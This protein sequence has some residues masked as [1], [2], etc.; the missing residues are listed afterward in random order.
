MRRPWALPL[1]PLYWCGL[2]V[3]NALYRWGW[4]RAKRLAWPVVSVGSLSAGGAG[5]TPVVMMLAE[6]LG[7]HGVQVDVL[8]RGYGRG[9]GVVEEVDAEGSARRFGDEPLEM[10]RRGLRVVMGADRWAAG[11]FAE[12]E[13]E[14]K[15]NTVATEEKTQRSLRVAV[16]VLDDG[17][18]HRRLARDLDLALLT[19]EDVG[20]WLLPAGNLREPMAA[21]ARAHVVVVRDEEASELAGVI[22]AN[23]E[24][25]VWMVRRELVLPVERPQRSVVFC[26]IARPKS[27][28]A[29]L[30]QAGCATAGEIVFPDHHAYTS[31]HFDLLIDAAAHAG[32]DGFLTTA[33][34]AVKI[35]PEERMKLEKIG[36]VIVAALRVTLVDEDAAMKTLRRSLRLA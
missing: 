23:T 21:L 28:L 6:L 15:I 22:A 27:F 9:S 17:F 32:A 11:K 25:D 4:L 12:P 20:D 14:Q 26:G 24:A 5:K 1:A 29:M 3:K 18:Q 36:P 16:H 31:E 13:R 30:R 7:R 2:R 35:P 19:T 34:D 33:K 10:A 8:S